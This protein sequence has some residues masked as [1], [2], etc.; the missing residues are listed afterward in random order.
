MKIFCY[1]AFF[2]TIG[3]HTVSFANMTEEIQSSLDVDDSN[4]AI[5]DSFKFSNLPINGNESAVLV[6]APGMNMDGSFFLNE[7]H[8]IEFAK[9]NNLGLIA[10]N[11][12]S[13]PVDMYSGERKG[14]YFPKESGSGKAL[15]DEI[16]RLYG[17]D[18][19][20]IIYGFSGGAQFTGRFIDFAPDRIISWSAYS[21]Q[22]WDNP[23]DLKEGGTSARG[24]VAC[25]DLD[26]SRWQPSFAFFYR[27]REQGKKWIW[28]G[29]KNT[30]HVRSAKLESF[31]RKFFEKE[32]DLYIKQIKQDEKTE[33]YADISTL[34]QISIE[35]EE[36]SMGLSC[37]FRDKEIY[38]IWKEI[39]A[40]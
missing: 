19:P 6:L 3:F 2:I 11:Y 23:K 4:K 5:K 16:K 30:E 36:I 28:V 1:F 39:H 18:L 24:I 37:P 34:K 33:L 22:F 15:L 21:A 12:K 29:R 9:N 31:I 20:I 8:W 35:E 10:L 7:K 17:K 40:P 14:Y 25:G 13:N 38:D 32:L 26:G 27:G